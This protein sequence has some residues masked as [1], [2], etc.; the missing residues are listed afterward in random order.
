MSMSMAGQLK[1]WIGR[2][3]AK[4]RWSGPPYWTTPLQPKALRSAG[5]ERKKPK[6]YQV[7]GCGG[8][9]DRTQMMAEWGRS[10]V[11]TRKSMEVS[12]QLSGH[13]MYGGLWHRTEG[14]RTRT[15]HGDREERYIAATWSGDGASLQW[16]TGCNSMNGNPGAWARAATSEP[17]Q[18]NSTESARLRHRNLDPLGPGTLWHRRKRRSRLSGELSPRRKRK[19]S[20]RA[21]IHLALQ[22]G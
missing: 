8:Q 16:L 15:C 2:P 14:D 4:N 9:M 22:Q 13:C 3:Q 1:A 20:D 6:S 7:S 17:V 18:Q 11:Q 12:P 19:L 21:A 10:S 5:Q